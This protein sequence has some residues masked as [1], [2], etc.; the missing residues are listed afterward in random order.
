MRTL[1]L[2]LALATVSTVAYTQKSDSFVT[3]KGN[4]LTII[5]IGHGTLMFQYQD[6]VIHIDPWSRLAEYDSFPKADYV[7]ITHHHG[8]HLDSVA[9]SKVVTSNTQ[10]YWTKICAEQSKLKLEG[11]VVA[12]GDTIATPDFRLIA[13]PAYNIVNKR[14]NG[15]PF[16]PKGEGNGYIFEFDNLRVYVAGDTEN[17]PEMQNLGPIDIAFL[18]A[19]LPYT[20]S[21]E[22]FKTAAIMVKP[23]ILYPYHTGDTNFEEFAKSLYDSQGIELRL[24][25][26]K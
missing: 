17:I 14:P 22:M 15:N 19:N 9:L 16:H 25:N 1:I 5:H 13:V 7:F 2:V 20:M 8:D 10:L 3:A 4:S 12:N 6:K 24:R 11:K 23:K 18:P 21:P 26:M